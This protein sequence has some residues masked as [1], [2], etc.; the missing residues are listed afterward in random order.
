[1]SSI[2]QNCHRPA[3]YRFSSGFVRIIITCRT[4]V[5]SVVNEFNGYSCVTPKIIPIL[6]MHTRT[7][8]HIIKLNC[9]TTDLH[10]VVQCPNAI[11][12][13]YYELDTIHTVT[14]C[15]RARDD[16]STNRTRSEMALTP[17][18]STLKLRFIR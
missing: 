10:R 5:G 17:G 2:A 11:L 9:N 14:P 3:G 13:S 1:M 8:V 4:P 7:S 16:T 12:V 15:G 18:C 6:Y